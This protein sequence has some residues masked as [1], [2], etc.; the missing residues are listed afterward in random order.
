MDRY[1]VILYIG[2]AVLGRVGGEMMITDPFVVSKI[3]H[4]KR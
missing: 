3:G 1:P 2:T 4:S